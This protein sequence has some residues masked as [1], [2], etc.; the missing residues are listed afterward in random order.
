MGTLTFGSPQHVCTIDDRALMHLQIVI[1]T[2]LRRGE[3]FR[4]W[5]DHEG[6]PS[7]V[8]MSPDIPL[9][10]HFHGPTDTKINPEWVSA[11]ERTAGSAQGLHLLEEPDASGLDQPREPVTEADV[12]GQQMQDALNSRVLIERA[13]GIVAQAEQVGM[14]E[15]LR[16]LEDRARASRR[17]L[18]AVAREIVDSIG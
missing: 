15:A 1:I 17:T 3:R 16:R 8:W 18:F 7:M 10:F 2:K 6:G 4:F 11:L 13:K 12:A 14:D 5:C 9:Q